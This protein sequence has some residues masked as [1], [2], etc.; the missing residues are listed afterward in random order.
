MTVA[1]IAERLG[2]GTRG[3]LNHLLY[4]RSKLCVKYPLSRTDPC[5]NQVNL[6][7]LSYWDVLTEADAKDLLKSGHQLPNDLPGHA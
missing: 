3:P 2:M 6:H 7:F 4:L 1:W 5:S